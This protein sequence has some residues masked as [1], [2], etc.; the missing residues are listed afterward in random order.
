[1]NFS[2]MPHSTG[3]VLCAILLSHA[4]AVCGANGTWQSTNTVYGSSA[5]TNSYNWS[6]SPY[7]SAAQ[8]ATFS[9]SGNGRTVIDLEGLSSI[10]NIAFSGTS[11]AAYTLGA[12]GPNA[13]VLTL[14]ANA[15]LQLSSTVANPQRVD[16]RIQLGADA[17]AGSYSVRNDSPIHP[18]TLAGGAFHPGSGASKALTFLGNGTTVVSG[19]IL[20]NGVN[21]L[22]VTNAG[23]GHLALVGASDFPT[24]VATSGV[25]TLAG[26][27][28]IRYAYLNNNAP[29][30]VSGSNAISTLYINGTGATVINVT[31]G[32]LSFTSGGGLMIRAEQNAVINGP[33][34]LV[35]SVGS[36]SNLTGDNYCAPGKT[37]T[38][39]ADITGFQGLE[40]WSGSGSWIL[41]GRND[42][43]GTLNMGPATVVCSK[44]GM[45]GAT[46]SN[47]GSGTTVTM[48]SSTTK[49]VYIGAGETTDRI[50]SFSSTGVTL[51]QSGTGHL[52]FT[53][54]PTASSG[55][56]TLVLQGSTPGTAEFAAAIP[57]SSTLSLLKNGT[58]TWILSAN[59]T[60]AG[61]TTVSGGTLAL[62]GNAVGKLGSSTSYV[63]NPGGT[64]R[65][66]NAALSNSTDRLRDASPVTLNGGTL[67]FA[68]DGGDADFSETAGE[69]RVSAGASTVTA[70]RAAAGRTSALTFAS[71][72]H[73]DGATADFAG[74]GLGDPD[75]RNRIL[76]ADLADGPL[77]G[78]VTANGLPAAYTSS[79]GVHAADGSSYTAIAAR[80]PSTLPDTPAA[81]VMIATDGTSG[82]IDLAAPLTRVSYLFQNTATPATLDTADK[83]LQTD[84]IVIPEDKAS[85][86]VGQSPNDGTLAPVT[87]GGALTL[88][89]SGGPLTVN[90]ALV[91]NASA[92]S[93]YKIGPGTATLASTG[94]LSGT[95]SVSGGPL[96]LANPDAL[97]FATLASGVSF[98]DSIGAF[99][100]GA[101]SGLFNLTLEDTAAAPV[102]LSVSGGTHGGVLSGSGALVKTGPATLALSGANTHA[103]GTSVEDGTLTLLSAAAAGAG[104]LT[105][106]ATLHLAATAADITYPFAS[107]SGAG[108]VLAPLGTGG[109]LAR[110]PG[111][112]SAFTGTWLAG[113]N[114]GGRIL[115]NGP[116]SPAATLVVATN[117]QLIAYPGTGDNI[118]RAHVILYGG[119]PSDTYG[120]LR[121]DNGVEWA[122]PVTLRGPMTDEQDGTLGNGSGTA[123]VSGVIGDD[124]L[125]IGLSKSHSGAIILTGSNTF[126]GPVW[127]KNG[128]LGVPRIGAAAA[129][130]APLGNQPDAD[131]AALA[132]G[133]LTSTG[134]LNYLGDGETADREIRLAGT[135]GGAGLHHNGTN[136]L[137]FTGNITSI[138]AGNKRLTLA[139]DATTG[140]GVLAGVFSDF[141][142]S[143][144]NNLYKN[145]WGTWRLE[146]AHTFKG[147]VEIRNGSLVVAHS[148]AFGTGPKTVTAANNVVEAGSRNLPH[149]VLDGSMAPLTLPA[150]ITFRTSSQ[151]DGAL[152]N[153]AGDNTVLGNINL[154]SGDGDTIVNSAAG[155]LTLAGRVYPP[156]DTSRRLRFWG[157]G[158]G[159]VSGVISN[160]ATAALPV[161]K[162]RGSGT[163]TLTGPN[164]H[165]GLTSSDAGTLVIGGPAGRVGGPL[166]AT[167]AGTLAVSNAPDANLAD[168]LPD[169]AA[170]TLSNGGAFRFLH[171]GGDADYAETAGALTVSGTNA[172]SVT[173]SRAA[174]GHTSILTF[175][176]L[177]RTA[178]ATLDFQ[179]DGLG[180]DGRNRVFLTAQPDGILGLWATCNGSALAAYSAASGVYAADSSLVEELP[181]K[182]PAD[183]PDAASKVARIAIEGTNGPLTLASASA[184]LKGLLQDSGWAST[185][186]L[187]GKALF[188]DDLRI[189][190][191]KADLTLGSSRDEGT[192][193]PLTPVGTLSLVN[194]SAST[195]TVNATLTNSAA[196]SLTTIGDVT[197]AGAPRHSGPTL[198]VS[199][200]LTVDVAASGTNALAGAVSGP[201]NLVKTGAGA[202]ALNA[203]NS[204]FNGTLT[205]S[206][207]I[208]QPKNNASLG[209]T[210]GTTVIEAGATLDLGATAYAAQGVNFGREVFIV[211]G[212]GVGGR[213]ALVNSSNLS[214]YNALHDIVLAG[215]ATFGGEQAG[216]R[217]DIRSTG[218]FDMGGHT[219]TKVGANLFGITSINVA[220]PGN[221]DVREGSFRLETSTKL[222]GDAANTLT[223]RSGA[224]FEAYSLPAPIPWSL[225][226]EDNATFAAV[227]GSSTTLNIWSGPAALAGTGLFDSGSYSATLAGEISGPGRLLKTGTGTLYLS[228]QNN[229]YGG[230]TTLSNGTLR[231][232]N[233]GGL[234]NFAT[235]GAF[236]ASPATTVTNMLVLYSGDGTAG[237]T[238]AQ[239]NAL[240]ATAPFNSTRSTFAVDTTAASIDY[241]LALSGAM[242]FSQYGSGTLVQRAPVNITGTFNL[243]NSGVFDL[244]PGLSATVAGNTY[245]NDT[246][247]MFLTNNN[248]YAA[249][250][251]VVEE[252]GRLYLGPGSTMTLPSSQDFHVRGT[253]NAKAFIDGTLTA[254][255]DI[256]IAR[257]ASG[258]RATL[259]VNGTVT[260]AHLFAG[261][262]GTG[263]AGAVIQN[264][265]VM[266]IGTNTTSAPVFAVGNQGSYGY[267]QL[268]GGETRTGQFSLGD[269]SASGDYR[270]TAAVADFNGGTLTLTKS[271]GWLLHDWNGGYGAFN[272]RG[273]TVRAPAGSNDTT[274]NHAADRDG[275]GIIN[276]LGPDGLLDA[277]GN[278][279]DRG[280]DLARSAGNQAGYLN[281]NGGTLLANTVRA[282]SAATPTFINF[283]GGALR[284]R[285]TTSKAATFL[286]GLTYA[287]VYSGGAVIDSSNA[288]VTVAQNLQSPD[289]CGVVFVPLVSGGAG[290]IGAPFVVLS[291]GSGT[292]ATAV[293]EV[294]LALGQVTALIVTSPGFGYQPGDTLTAA[295]R[296][297]GFTSP[298]LVALPV[299]APNAPAGGLTKLGSGTLTL[300][301][302]NTYG[303]A[304]AVSAGTL[305][306]ATP[307]S[308][309]A[310]TDVTVSAGATLDLNGATVTNA[311]SGL[312]TVANGTLVTTISP[313]GEHALGAETLTLASATLQGT[314]LADVTAGGASDHLTL[315]GDVNLAGLTLHLVDPA[316]L[317]RTQSYMIAKLNGTWS[318]TLATDNLPDARWHT[319]ILSDGTVRLLFVNGTIL[320]LK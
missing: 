113:T 229:T 114:G 115:F 308:L 196:F 28:L 298:A 187:P 204:S 243:F 216:G 185:V 230:G 14:S 226:M 173:A 122:G 191:G 139:G 107:L 7:P 64:L 29:L 132:L 228:G 48:A 170:V 240:L 178:P 246:S 152:I 128:T 189:A 251:F 182:G 279:N 76:F 211:S 37:V 194:D 236:T 208:L 12:G 219:L 183:L 20:S 130:Y 147:S 138:T 287:T 104:P 274:L 203:A 31:D 1:M 215:D 158:D 210:A 96:I 53:G 265:G 58:G 199:G 85:V 154:V 108:M 46:D 221:I 4:T 315:N 3:L 272:I 313:A 301:G 303:G 57:N 118:H 307:L 74:P 30:Y 177:A 66:D 283:N 218:S 160:G 316:E 83:A 6:A 121:I 143:S 249:N 21:T 86:T 192:L 106:N 273:G 105:N 24:Y 111:D 120:N 312:G 156:T 34:K 198:I 54:T 99:N 310:N 5:W 42:F 314:Y 134:T 38:I 88:S 127:V 15:I 63:I 217:L 11:A 174:D 263:R 264:G 131:T 25:T 252:S 123:V 205:L 241:A 289:G 201:G 26:T 290:Y 126:S 297:G 129:G 299:L 167:L 280:V 41:N 291:G 213:G 80:G 300:G 56:K 136:T 176:S 282:G 157:D 45:K 227:Q 171:P 33:G 78:W 141:D 150:D 97:A 260:A 247:T 110:F 145:G 168:R 19:N 245:V 77:P 101:L 17:A 285:P 162:E 305:K 206:G 317:N 270:Y 309:P 35:V 65:L 159:E 222:N 257:N 50:F 82:P 119:D 47:L 248:T 269:N 239:L 261:H 318:G 149:V 220:N 202:L 286:Q 112:F 212:A 231:I 22:T 140:P 153:A 67:A 161:W 39:N 250:A 169:T 91:D 190:P 72:A 244:G 95:V 60:F 234:P 90:A 166:A 165:T 195:L 175:A 224:R 36:G 281:L 8:T 207:G 302:T 193:A 237:W 144:T 93:L 296:G 68:N 209:T 172:C 266:H 10:S 288:S 276:L 98:G 102:S 75:S 271:G 9:G 214:Q 255:R 277:T 23:P 268:N 89:S 238:G 133:R 84:A 200:D 100:V 306:L 278:G 103:G 2:N 267:F 125:G 319:N 69:L 164:T 262:N 117:S 294:D 184:S 146:T 49:L 18:L 320:F 188:A 233:P 235:P 151:V 181:A 135:T 52:V 180:L 87:P 179:G 137:T 253:Q 116:D 225:A 92:S 148:Q 32:H 124:D 284:A 254:A 242:S 186:A 256:Y 275:Y 258:D 44:I 223:L 292:G 70:S 155:R 40:L 109:Y 142:A 79:R 163:W 81:P 304:T 61:T 16:A 27:N 73:T 13:Q 59:N 43:Q 311:V 259:V 51:D 55:E 293:A 197:L 71:L 62:R 232:T 94:T 295:L